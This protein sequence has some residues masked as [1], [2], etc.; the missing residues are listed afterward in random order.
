MTAKLAIVGN[1][2]VGKSTLFNRLTGKHVQIGNWSGVTSQPQKG[3]LTADHTITIYD[4]PGVFSITEINNDFSIYQWIRSHQIT[5]IIQVVHD[6]HLKRDLCM[7]QQLQLLG[8][9]LRLV[10]RGDKSR[11]LTFSECVRDF[12]FKV[13]LFE[14][15]LNI[16]PFLSESEATLEQDEVLKT[17]QEYYQ[18]LAFTDTSFLHILEKR[19]GL[20]QAIVEKM[21]KEKSGLQRPQA[22]L[23]LFMSFFCSMSIVFSLSI[24]VGGALAAMMHYPLDLISMNLRPMVYWPILE[25]FMEGIMIGCGL[26]ADFFFPLFILY[27]LLR[28]MEESGYSARVAVAMDGLFRRIGLSGKVFLPMLMSLG[29]N[30]PAIASTRMLPQAEK[31]KA[32]LMLPFMT[33]SARLATY[34]AITAVYCPESGAW[35]VM[36]LYILGF[37]VS[38]MTALVSKK[39]K[40]AG[41]ST[42]LV[43]SIPPLDFQFRFRYIKE[44]YAQAL[45][46]VYQASKVV[47]IGSIVVHGLVHYAQV[48]V[49]S[50]APWLLLLFYPFDYTLAQLPAILGI[51][52][53]FLAKEMVIATMGAYHFTDVNLVMPA[54]I[55]DFFIQMFVLGGQH[56]SQF[57]FSWMGAIASIDDTRIQQAQLA[58]IFNSQA[59]AVSFL[60]FVGLYFPCI[61]T[62]A[63]LRRIVGSAKAYAVVVWSVLLAYVIAW[64][65][66]DVMSDPG[67]RVFFLGLG[68]SCLIFLSM[69][70][71]YQGRGR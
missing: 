56:L 55:I 24:G 63:I 42:P 5:H 19:Y 18:Q 46:F 40:I 57:C 48:L 1:A 8:L 62:I 23:Q 68:L 59:Q 17:E 32:A 65:V 47:V 9:P 70:K 37:L 45:I 12:N 20:A 10:F 7:T 11:F 61:S 35:V 51:I 71:R 27:F 54:G 29:C 14:D 4:T 58:G 16:L 60:V 67:H 66:Y 34:V 39:L 49:E 15:S 3:C 30:V 36:L 50:V 38:I 64:V 33:C 44:A 69:K 13:T 6:R 2:N 41:A 26:L 43:M 53:G 22:S 31:I 21:P 25:I 28:W 52:S